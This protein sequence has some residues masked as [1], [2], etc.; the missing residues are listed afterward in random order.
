MIAVFKRELGAYFKGVL[1]YLFAAFVL[2]FAG[3][4]T[5]AYNLSGAYA[6]FEYA[7][8][9]IAFIYLIAVPILTMRVVA[10]E[11]RQRTDQLLYALPISMTSV[12]VGKYLAL[13]CVLALPTLIMA[14]YPL[15][16]TQFGAVTLS[17]A[18]GALIAFFMLG[19]CLLSIGLFISS[20]TDSPVGAAV[21]TLVTMLIL[22]FIAD[23]ASF[24]STD[25]STSMLALML[26][27]LV[28][29]CVLYGLTKNPIAATATGAVGMG[30][31]Y[32][33]YAANSASFEGLFANIMTQLSVFDR[34]YGFIDGVFD[35]T[36]VVY[37]A[38][39]VAVFLFLT[40]QAM[41]K[42]RWNA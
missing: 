7:L 26:L 25:G 24:L 36:A 32:G 15:I 28:F 38:S 6:N 4:Y 21:V 14:L 29:A 2:I 33:L 19:A 5:M 13:L 18:Y 8:S 42:R 10:E 41:E 34:F 31:I 17:T 20:M 39:I 11:R 27:M 37:F 30:V 16:L 12:V 40:V 35:L 1:G 22:Y 3:I 9:S 23:L